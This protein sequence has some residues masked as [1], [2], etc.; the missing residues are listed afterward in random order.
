MIVQGAR[1]VP[2]IDHGVLFFFMV[3]IINK[4]HETAG[5]DISR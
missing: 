3:I 4:G 2:C 1:G 5:G